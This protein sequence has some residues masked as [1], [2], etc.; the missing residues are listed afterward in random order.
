MEDKV[1]PESLFTQEQINYVNSIKDEDLRGHLLHQI[2]LR[3][4]MEADR[5]AFEKQSA[6]EPS[7]EKAM[8]RL[9]SELSADK[10]EGSYYYSWQA[11]I[12]MAFKDEFER[13]YPHSSTGYLFDLHLIANNAAKNFLDIL[14]K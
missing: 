5:D 2:R 13:Q 4:N 1:T 3:D 8:R 11:N 10:S 9:T 6:V 12:A 7:I 14:C